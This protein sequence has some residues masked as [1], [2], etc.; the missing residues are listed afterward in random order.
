MVTAAPAAH[1]LPTRVGGG[2]A[3]VAAAAVGG[4]AVV[5]APGAVLAGVALAV[6]VAAMV[7]RIEWSVLVYVAVEPFGDLANGVVPGAVKLVGA[8]LFVA[9]VARLCIDRRPVALG[10]PGLRAAGALLVVLLASTALA[11]GGA[12]DAPEVALRYASY[13]AV[14][15]V[16][17]DTVAAGDPRTAAT[18][19]RR[20]A[21]VFVLSCAAAAVVGLVTLF[22]EGGRA[23]GPLEDPNDF[24]FFLVAAAPFALMLARDGRRQRIL[25]G[26]AGL[27]LLVA[28]LGTFSRGALLGIGAVVA[29]AAV[30]RLVPLRALAAGVVAVVV[31]ALAVSVV[32]SDVVGRSL[33]EKEHVADA[34]VDSRYASWTIAAEMTADRPLLGHGPG[35]FGAKALDYLPAGV[36]DTAHL[37][38]AHQMYL[39]VS[40]E[41]GLLGLL[42]FLA[43]I[44]LGA[45]GALRARR[46]PLTAPLGA[47]TVASLAGVLVAACFLSEQYYLPV[48]LLA[49]LGIA[50]DPPTT[51]RS[52]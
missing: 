45:R 26:V 11:G 35:S 49:A 50:L 19:A 6:V 1:R 42:A 2:A 46:D 13:L 36:V 39:D 8:L 23:G 17:V 51:R 21:A 28:I 33:D 31:T 38:V 48:W 24:A 34:N 22:T 5:L 16:V 44:G 18:R 32:A 4:Y 37:D 29:V 9:W 7:L 52:H 20:I 27:L 25:Y 43:V 12:P 30:L 47:A 10:H 41:L 14:L 3:V 40:S 15:L